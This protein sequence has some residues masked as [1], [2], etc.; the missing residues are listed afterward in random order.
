MSAAKRKTAKTSVLESVR[1]VG[2]ARARALLARFG[3]LAG[4]KAADKES[5]CTVPGITPETAD[6]IL[7]FFQKRPHG[8]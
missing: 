5:L 4:V 2:K 6:R 3:G 1:G 7:Q 8:S